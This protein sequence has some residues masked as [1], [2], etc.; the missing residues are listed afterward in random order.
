MVSDFFFR[1][2]VTLSRPTQVKDAAG[3]T[4]RKWAPLGE[5]VMAAVQPISSREAQMWAARQVTVSHRIYTRQELPYQK[6][7][8]LT[9]DRGRIFRVRGNMNVATYDQLWHID[10]QEVL[11]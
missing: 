5:P 1:S 4:K 6:G 10:C 8:R 7:D 11:R 3:G 2:W 9:D